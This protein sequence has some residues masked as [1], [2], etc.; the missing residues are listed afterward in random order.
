MASNS[1]NSWTYFRFSW[2]D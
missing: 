1:L 2:C